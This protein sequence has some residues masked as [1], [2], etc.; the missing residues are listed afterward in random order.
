MGA[1][2]LRTMTDYFKGDVELAL[3]A[4]NGGAASVD[5]WQKDPRSRTATTCCVGSVS[6][7]R[8]STWS[9]SF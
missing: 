4:Y 6:E 3:M 8:A 5:L 2:Y 1:S 9:E 7:R